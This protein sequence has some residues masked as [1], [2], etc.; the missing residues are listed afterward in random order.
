MI[1]LEG[2]NLTIDGVQADQLDLKVTKRSFIVP[3]L[4]DLLHKINALYQKQYNKPLWD[5]KLLNSG[6]FLSGSSL[7]FFNV[8][9]ISDEEF[10]A[11]KPKVGDI[12]T[13]VN[14]DERENLVQFLTTLQGKKIGDATLLGFHTAGGEQYSGLWQLGTPPS[15]KVQIDFEFVEFDQNG[16]TDWA[17]FSHSSSW[18]D[19]SLGIKGVFHKW[20]TQSLAAITYRDFL[21]RKMVGRGKARTEQDVP[22]QDTMLSFAVSSKEGGGLRAKYLPVIDPNTRKPL[23][24]DGLPV[25]TA[26]PTAGYIQDVQ[27]IFTKLFGKKIGEKAIENTWS[28]DGILDLMNKLMTKK[29]KA[30]VF[31]QF[32]QKTIGPDAQGMYKNDPNR[33]LAEKSVAINHAM[34]K[35]GI[36]RPDNLDQMMMDYKKSY[37]MTP[38]NEDA[39]PSYKRKGIPHIYN[40]GSSVEMKDAEFI[41]MCQEIANMGGK[42]DDADISLKVDGGP[43]R[44]GKDPQ[45]KAFFMTGKD[46]KPMYINNY[47]DYTRNIGPELK[48]YDEVLKIVLSSDFIK[49]IPKDTIVEAEMMYTPAGKTDAKGI[50]FV[51]IAYDPKKLGSVL[52]IVP[53]SVKTYS[54]GE[55]SPYSDKIKQMLMSYSNKEIKM[56]NNQLSQTN[57]DVSKIVNPIAKNADKLLAAIKSR[58]DSEQKT[59]AKELL[60]EAR[61]KLSDTIIASPNI[62][63]KDQLGN[64]IEGLVIKLPSGLAA[65]VTSSEMKERMAKNPNARATG[66]TVVVYGGGFQPFHQGH[67]SSYLQAKKAFPNADFYVAASGNVKE[68]PIPY[69]EKKFLATQAGVQPADFPDIAVSTPINPKEIL[70]KYDPEKDAFILVRSERDPMAYTKKDGSPGYFQPYNPN[71][72][73]QPFANHGYVFVTSKHD[74]N[75]NGNSVYSG[76]QVRDMYQ[77][78]DDAGR[79]SIIKQL[80]PRSKQHK[81]IKQILDK[82]L[83]NNAVATMEDIK[84]L[85]NRI[86]PLINEATGEQKNRLYKLL[87]ASKKQLE[88]ANPAQQAAIAIA[89]KKKKGVK[90][91]DVVSF[92]KKKSEHEKY[93]DAFSKQHDDEHRYGVGHIECP[94][95]GDVNCD[96]DCDESQA[97]GFNEHVNSSSSMSKFEEGK[98][99]TALGAI[100]LGAAMALNP[101]S[102]AKAADTGVSK[103]TTTATQSGTINKQDGM[104]KKIHDALQDMHPK[105]DP[106]MLSTF[107]DSAYRDYKATG[108]VPAEI[109]QYYKVMQGDQAPASGFSQKWDAYRAAGSSNG[110]KESFDKPYSFDWVDRKYGS[111]AAI[112]M[113]EDGT[114]LTVAFD[115]ENHNADEENHNEYVVEFHRNN[116]FVVTGE[117]DSQ[118]VFATVLKAIKEFIKKKHPNKLVFEANKIHNQSRIKLYNKLVERY[119]NSWGYKSSIDED[120]HRI[121][122][123]LSKINKNPAAPVEESQDYLPEK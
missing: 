103:T 15:I 56:V 81:Q 22:M 102:S 62:K 19:L 98:F 13:M 114:Y 110:V 121:T 11:K 116:K 71:Q 54:T 35:L 28:F 100:G 106:G 90:E 105:W 86:K 23:V 38:V 72:P 20:L 18:R 117:G 26:A 67:L 63:G 49:K 48:K 57:L 108:K 65:K 97:D 68:R 8:K 113:L 83:V 51:R 12:D 30:I 32:L 107:T 69:Q 17:K 118:R 88:A 78:A 7:H 109:V 91:G 92:K 3:I 25:M 21:Q 75:I 96:Y 120:N 55:E 104:Y 73:L 29:Q 77:N 99:G 24:K 37:R 4:N 87:E 70:Q 44:F 41:R 115:E 42:L 50:R 58:G 2:G 123:I 60:A 112:T 27:Q 31:Q 1:L 5:P 119:A 85:Y 33:D 53:H 89:K 59:K 45:G 95:C 84:T 39:E 52:T 79:L 10:V 36:S 9:G 94:Y 34:K 47:G 122:Y 14:R 6:A 111:Y 40:P 101:A 80:Y 93:A 16:P 46:A 76:T 61:K 64:M 82:Y 43:I 66:K 74:F